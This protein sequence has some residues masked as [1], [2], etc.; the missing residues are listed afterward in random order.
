MGRVELKDALWD[1]VGNRPLTPS[2]MSEEKQ[3]RYVSISPSLMRQSDNQGCFS[4]MF[5]VNLI[6]GNGS[7]SDQWA[8]INYSI[9]SVGVIGRLFG[10]KKCG[11]SSHAEHKRK[12][13]MR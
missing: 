4:K 3:Q 5:A 2:K 7:I 8:E 1:A 11:V 13:Q 10:Q 6:Y 12:C 9:I